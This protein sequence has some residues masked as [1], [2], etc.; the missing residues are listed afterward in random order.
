M[1]DL[2]DYR[3]FRIRQKNK[4]R[5]IEEPL[6][7]LKEIQHEH[8]KHIYDFDFTW[9]PY[10]FGMKGTSTIQNAAIHVGKNIIIKADIKKFFPT[11]KWSHFEKMLS[12]A[13]DPWKKNLEA[14]ATDGFVQVSSTIRL[15]TG[16]PTSP[17]LASICFSP[18]DKEILSVTNK[19]HLSYTRYVD[20]LTFSGDKY[21]KGFVKEL[22]DI[23]NSQGY[24]LN[25]KKTRVVYNSN[26]QIV[27]GVLVNNETAAPR[28]FR[29]QLRAELDKFAREGLIFDNVVMGKLNYLRQLQPKH[30]AKLIQYY[31]KRRQFYETLSAAT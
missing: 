10:V 1:R 2:S 9:A 13:N 14:V 28:E 4:W 29:H 24:E 3:V 6:P 7:F 25:L 21:P 18:V 31:N 8:L 19:Y 22:C 30:Y 12:F 16:A 5:I 11:T 27:T 20:D 17:F 23:V 26:Q 15:P